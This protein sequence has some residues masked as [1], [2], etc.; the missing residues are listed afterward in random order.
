MNS[1]YAKFLEKAKRVSGSWGYSVNDFNGKGQLAVEGQCFN[2]KF[3]LCSKE[4]TL[5]SVGSK[6]VIWEF[7]DEELSGIRCIYSDLQSLF[8][9]IYD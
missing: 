8:K 4:L 2:L 7:L 9:E 5:N 6:G 1:E 3:D